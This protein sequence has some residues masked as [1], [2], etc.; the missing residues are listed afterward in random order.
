MSITQ[1]RKLRLRNI[2]YFIDIQKS[3]ATGQSTDIH[4][5][6]FS[7]QL[8]LRLFFTP[9]LFYISGEFYG[10]VHVILGFFLV[11]ALICKNTF[12][13]RQQQFNFVRRQFFSGFSFSTTL[14]N[15]NSSFTTLVSFLTFPSSFPTPKSGTCYN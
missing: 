15:I 14:S 13:R 2:K 8:R 9:P 4:C 7:P 5:A 6:S 3:P 12:Q 11:T 1:T 10:Q